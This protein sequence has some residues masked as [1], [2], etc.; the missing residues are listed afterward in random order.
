MN[1]CLK[2]LLSL[3]CVAGL[4]AAA[5]R[6]AHAA[7]TNP[8]PAAAVAEVR[9]PFSSPFAVSQPAAT[10]NALTSSPV[11]VAPPV[12]LQAAELRRALHVQG[13]VQQGGRCY[14]MINGRL[15][16]TGDIV[17]VRLGATL[18]RFRVGT[19][20]ATTVNFEPSP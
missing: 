10:T 9:D 4:W 1:A 19:V 3:G 17:Q 7:D 14:A 16:T 5:P 2:A 13:Y 20:T 8:P 15:V 18:L 12:Q 6:C 11:P